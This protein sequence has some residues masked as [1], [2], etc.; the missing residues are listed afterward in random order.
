M[1]EVSNGIGLKNITTVHSR[2]EEINQ[3]FDY[4]V[5]R[6]VAPV[7][8]LVKWTRK[9]FDFMGKGLGLADGIIA[10]KGGD[11]TQEIKNYKKHTKVKPLNQWFKED[12]F[13]TKSLVYIK[14]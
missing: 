7:E 8:D 11:L 1:E 3:K 14:V 12:F 4:V 13:E 2:V 5:T 10:L 9:S 6:A